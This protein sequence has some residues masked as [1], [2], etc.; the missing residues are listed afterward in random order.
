MQPPCCLT[1]IIRN[2][3]KL[4]KKLNKEPL[5]DVMFEVR[6]ASGVPA[7]V[8]FPGV[9][10][11][12]LEGEKNIESLPIAQLPKSVRDADPNLKYAPLSRIDWGNFFI[13][14]SDYSVLISCKYPYSG[15]KLFKEAI[16][17]VICIL[18]ESKIVSGVDRYSMKYVDLIPTTDIQQIVSMINFS[19]SIADHQLE[20]EQFHLRIEIPRDGLTHAVQ[21]VSS[22]QAV[23]HNGTK[24][25]GLIVDV[26][27]FV[28]Q[29][30]S[31]MHSLSTELSER[32][33]N[34]HAAN[35][36]MF[37][38]CLRPDAIEQLEPQ[39]D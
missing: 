1:Y 20:K 13:S 37:F 10:F 7:S 18:E 33:E 31:S 34:I 6:F 27:T 21:V 5:I 17:T 12:R 29:Y 39:Y 28:S 25:E 14:V 32:L 11:N 15:W 35:K 24:M 22:A 36:A 8:I 16:T 23:L 2:M 9:L 19:V 3:N 38:N 4:P 30:S 26:D